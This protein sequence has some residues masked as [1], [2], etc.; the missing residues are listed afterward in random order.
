MIGLYFVSIVVGILMAVI[1]KNSMFKGRSSSIRYG[2]AELC[3]LP[4]AKNVIQLLWEKS[5]RFSSESLYDHL[6]SN[7]CDLVFTDV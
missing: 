7:H 4:S 2:I 5:K 3:V 1:A 6:F